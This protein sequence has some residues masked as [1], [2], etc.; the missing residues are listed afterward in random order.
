MILGLLQE[1]LN[2]ATAVAVLC[3]A[4]VAVA[5][6][7]RIPVVS[8]PIRWLGRTLIGDPISHAIGEALD[9]S[10]LGHR[11][12]RV[13][14]Q[15]LRNGGTSVRDAIDR[16]EDGQARIEEAQAR[17]NQ[18]LGDDYK[19]IGELQSGHAEIMRRL[20]AISTDS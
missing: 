3:G 7:A 13:E 1:I 4:L 5:A 15:L 9:R 6:A 17:T 14:S 18:R 12:E 2:I 16:L 19:A 10:T 20:D 8:R 11:V